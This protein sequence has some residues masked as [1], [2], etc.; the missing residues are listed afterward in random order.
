MGNK[1]W[2]SVPKGDGVWQVNITN[3]NGA[4]CV[5][6]QVQGGLNSLNVEQLPNGVYLI[7]LK[8]R[9]SG[10]QTVLRIIK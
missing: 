7:S 2:I 4:T 9:S 3:I 1:L 10:E 5:S 8:E 6:T